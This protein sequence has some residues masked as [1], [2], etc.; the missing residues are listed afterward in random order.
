METTP[1]SR[2]WFV[3]F[4]ISLLS[5]MMMIPYMSWLIKSQVKLV[6]RQPHAYTWALR[7]QGV[8][9]NDLPDCEPGEEQAAIQALASAHPQDYQIQLADSLMAEW[10][11]AKNAPDER[12]KRLDQ[13]AGVYPARATVYADML[14]Y[15]TE[16][17]VK[18]RRQAEFEHFVNQIPVDEI[19]TDPDELRPPS[20]LK[21]R[22]DEFERY[23][24][25]GENLE[26]ENA[27]FSMMR[28]I[29]LF[30]SHDNRLAMACIMSAA[31][32]L[33]WEDHVSDEL[34]ADWWLGSMAFG[35][36]SA[37]LRSAI[38][39]GVGSPHLEQLA[40]V[41]RTAAALAYRDGVDRQG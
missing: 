36:N 30:A 1:K 15:E 4:P 3:L 31:A 21:Q 29:G 7:A 13:L 19:K 16:R 34:D 2:P 22:L 28:A 35:D 33:Q 23:A 20:D 26:P 10:S 39:G 9:S 11:H 27:Y 17:E 32:K 5:I 41:G 18:V 38:Q 25:A 8:D 40:A 37:V 6:F 24:V 14:R 12:V